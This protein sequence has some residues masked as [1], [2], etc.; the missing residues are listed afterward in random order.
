[1]QVQTNV[2]IHDFE[3][4]SVARLHSYF[5]RALCVLCGKTDS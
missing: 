2:T 3:Y 1:M 4:C 5:L